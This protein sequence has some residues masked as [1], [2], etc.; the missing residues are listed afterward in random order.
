MNSVEEFNIEYIDDLGQVCDYILPYVVPGTIFLL[1]GPMSSGKTS[2]IYKL[3]SRLNIFCVSSPTYTIHQVY[4]YEHKKINHMDLHRLETA[5]DIDSAGIWDLFSATA[6]I[7]FIEWAQKIPISNW[8]LNFKILQ[9][10]INHKVDEPLS[11]V[12]K[13]SEVQGF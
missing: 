10:D 3:L 11:R 1:D 4:E 2:L 8:P 5:D 9:I 12:I 6:D 13:I 7:F